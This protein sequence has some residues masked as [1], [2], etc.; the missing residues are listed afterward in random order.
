MLAEA[1]KKYAAGDRMSALRLY[2]GVLQQVRPTAMRLAT[3][4]DA[5]YIL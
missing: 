1:K 5:W 4:C 3:A 2:E